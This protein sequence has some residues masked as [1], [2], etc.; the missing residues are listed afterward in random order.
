VLKDK[1]TTLAIIIFGFILSFFYNAL[2]I[3]EFKD[4]QIKLK[5]VKDVRFDLPQ[6]DTYLLVLWGP[7]L[8]KE[9]YFNN[10]SVMYFY[11]RERIELKE[12]YISLPPEFVNEGTNR[13]RIVSPITYSVRIRNYLG[14]LKS[15]GAFILFAN[16]KSLKRPFSLGKLIFL[17][18]FISLILAGMWYLFSFLLQKFFNISLRKFYFRYWFSYLPCLFL[19][20]IIFLFSLSP[21]RIVLSQQTFIGLVIFCTGIVKLCV[22]LISLWREKE[23]QAK[24]ERLEIQRFQPLGYR[25][26][27][28]FPI[29]IKQEPADGFIIAFMLLLIICALLLI[30]KLDLIAEQFANIAY[31]ALVIGVGIKLVQLVKEEW[32]KRGER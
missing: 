3:N 10:R 6:K 28:K 11:F 18:L 14:C 9:I 30:C 2:V 22:I 24:I 25:L 29:Y 5:E 1:K 15:K 16:S 27:A 26:M 31:F 13:L 21:Y 23:K 4:F 8:P 7:E 12:F 19:F 32:T 17:T 20:L